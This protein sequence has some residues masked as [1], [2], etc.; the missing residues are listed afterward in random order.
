MESGRTRKLL[1]YMKLHISQMH[2]VFE[3]SGHQGL[4]REVEMSLNSRT[5]FF[6]CPLR[7]HP[8]PQESGR[9]FHR[10]C[11]QVCTTAIPI[12]KLLDVLIEEATGSRMCKVFRKPGYD[13]VSGDYE[14]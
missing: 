13:I 1:F 9:P 7:H 14:E 11:R 3:N 10:A 8:T 6:S 12:R 4:F 2:N 5:L